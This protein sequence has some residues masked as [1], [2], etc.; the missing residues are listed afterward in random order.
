VPKRQTTESSRK[1]N[2]SLFRFVEFWFR[3]CKGKELGLGLDNSVSIVLSVEFH[4]AALL[5][6]FSFKGR[7]F[8]NGKGKK[9]KVGETV[10]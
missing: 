3:Q 10:L 1:R 2:D 4:I 9:T 6:G 7:K 8:N 5:A